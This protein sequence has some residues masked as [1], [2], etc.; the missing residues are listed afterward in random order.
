M[1]LPVSQGPSLVKSTTVR[2][3]NFTDKE[4]MAFVGRRPGSYLVKKF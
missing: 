4:Q 2:F 1:I 3:A